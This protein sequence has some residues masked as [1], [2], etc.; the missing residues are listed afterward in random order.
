[1]LGFFMLIFQRRRGGDGILLHEGE[2]FGIGGKVL[3]SGGLSEIHHGD[4]ECMFSV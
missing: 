3:I 2:K 4:C 1:M